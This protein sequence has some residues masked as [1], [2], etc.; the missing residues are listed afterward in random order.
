MLSVSLELVPA[1]T[2]EIS[3]PSIEICRLALALPVIS[4][5]VV[6]TESAL[7]IAVD[8]VLY[9]NAVAAPD[10]ATIVDKKNLQKKF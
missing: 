1:G 4:V 8:F 9:V 10:V 6:E 2:F 3:V 5:Q 7:L